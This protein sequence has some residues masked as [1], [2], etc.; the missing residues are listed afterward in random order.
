MHHI[1]RAQQFDGPALNKLF[2]QTRHIKKA[3]TD[4]E[5]KR[6]LRSTFPDKSFY[7]LFAEPST[8]TR[9][10]FQKAA[11]NLGMETMGT[12]NA[13]DFSSMVKGETLEHSIR[14]ILGNGFDVIAIRHSDNGAADRAAAVC[15]DCGFNT[16]IV[17]AGDGTSQ[18]PTQALL[19]LFTI[20][21]KFEQ[22]DGLTVVIGGD[23]AH[24][25]TAR[26]LA[27]LLSKFRVKLIFVSTPEL[28]VGEDIQAHLNERQID[29]RLETK[30]EDA[31]PE[32]DVVYWTRFQRERAGDSLAG[33]P[34]VITLGTMALFKPEAILLHPLPI[35]GEIAHE[36]DSHRQAYYFQQSDNGLPIRMALF[37]SILSAQD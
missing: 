34:H 5:Q 36:V 10:S 29:F 1:L 25:R 37:Q 32:A 17:N 31:V 15:D 9:T 2:H 12:E 30:V 16:A 4:P 6:A 21:E 26:S 27:Y 24:G 13:K 7:Y 19:D 11:T 18:H 14:V 33:S 22:I 35:V 23:L 28:T 20:H 8:R 3:L